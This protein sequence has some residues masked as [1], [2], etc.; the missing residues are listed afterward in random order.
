MGGGVWSGRSGS[1]GARYRVMGGR[2]EWAVLAVLRGV[3]VDRPGPARRAGERNKYWTSERRDGCG[4][5]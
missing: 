1:R 2:M 4:R 5:I 3:A